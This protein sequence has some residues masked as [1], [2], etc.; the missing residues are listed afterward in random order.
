[1]K[2]NNLE[3]S[4]FWLQPAAV[5]SGLVVV[6]GL[7]LLLSLGLAV[8]VHLSSWQAP[9][10]LLRFLAHLAVFLGAGWAGKK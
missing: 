4:G 8:V 10:R 2:K 6:F 3:T 9:H 7:L 5:F 1:M